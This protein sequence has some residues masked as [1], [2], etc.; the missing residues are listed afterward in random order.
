MLKPFLSS[1]LMLVSSFGTAI[2]QQGLEK[3]IVEKYYVAQAYDTTANVYAGKLPIN[4]VTYRI[5]ADLLPGY[6][7]S[8]AYGSPEHTLKIATTTTFYNNTDHGAI[9]PNVIPYRTLRKNTVMLDSW[10]SV[11]AAGEDCYGI[12]KTDD[13]TLETIK[14]EK[15]FLANTKKS[16]GIP[17]HQKDGIL[18]NDNVPRPTFFH[19]DNEAKIFDGNHPGG[20]F[21]VKDGAWACLEG[22]KGADSLTN[23]RVLIAQMT[24]DGELSF[25][26]NIQ[27]ASPIKGVSQRFVARNP[28]ENEIC[29]PSLI[30]TSGK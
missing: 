1:I 28:I 21:E 26:L 27:V 11:G 4:A 23:N 13:D 8:A 29:I 20:L 24:T 12:L 7:F 9:I 10:L 15:K 16:M 18:R 22:S 25:E 17:L 30:Y 6:K 2:A 3:I 19:I 14:H 5:Y